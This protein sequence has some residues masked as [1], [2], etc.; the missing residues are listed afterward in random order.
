MCQRLLLVRAKGAM[1]QNASFA[2]TS[3]LG[4]AYVRCVATMQASQARGPRDFLPHARFGHDSPVRKTR[5]PNRCRCW[6]SIVL[7]VSIAVR[8]LRN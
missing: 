3:V 2:T 7:A 8:G 4:A 1:L 6:P 5:S